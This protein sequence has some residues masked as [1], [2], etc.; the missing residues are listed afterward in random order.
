MAQIF[1][2]I[3]D[4]RFWFEINYRWKIAGELRP[5]S[6]ELECFDPEIAAKWDAVLLE[7]AEQSIED[8]QQKYRNVD[9]VILKRSRPSNEE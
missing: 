8:L 9:P 4:P 6:K 2:Y 7:L 1:V 3:P 5:K